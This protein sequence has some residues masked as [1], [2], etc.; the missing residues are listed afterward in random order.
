MHKMQ[1]NKLST[2]IT[3]LLFARVHLVIEIAFLQGIRHRVF[4]KN[5]GNTDFRIPNTMMMMDDDVKH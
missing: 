2:R 1:G 4:L 5:N 3:Y